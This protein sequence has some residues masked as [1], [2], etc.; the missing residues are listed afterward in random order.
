MLE[1][2]RAYY[3]I[4]EDDSPE[5]ARAKISARLLSM[6]EGYRE[7]LPFI[8]DLFGVPDPANPAPTIDPEQRQKRLH[9]A[10]SGR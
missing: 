8:F 6:D 9:G 5:T 4:A 2:W 10:R 7:D 1:L 3:G